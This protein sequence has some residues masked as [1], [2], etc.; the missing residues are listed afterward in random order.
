VL[1]TSEQRSLPVFGQKRFRT[2]TGINRPSR[3][4]FQAPFPFFPFP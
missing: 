4:L 3:H 2:K 1:P